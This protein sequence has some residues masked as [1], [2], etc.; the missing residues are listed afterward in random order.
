MSQKNVNNSASQ[1][2]CNNELFSSMVK[3]EL[4]YTDT[5]V[6]PT[7]SQKH[8]QLSPSKTNQHSLHTHPNLQTHEITV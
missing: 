6:L 5:R 2:N 1:P 7:Y 8:V 3:L 4:L